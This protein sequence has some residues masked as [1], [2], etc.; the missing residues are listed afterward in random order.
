M[1]KCARGT[2][3]S[4]AAHFPYCMSGSF[5]TSNFS[6]PYSKHAGRKFQSTP[7]RG[8]DPIDMAAPTVQVVP[9]P[10]AAVLTVLG[11][12]AA[13]LARRRSSC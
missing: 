1:H 9:E 11:V 12:A 8:G 2:L 6:Q 5:A 7:P 13:L 4:Y 3:P 10:G